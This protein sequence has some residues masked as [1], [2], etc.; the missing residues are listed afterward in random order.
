MSPEDQI[1]FKLTFYSFTIVFTILISHP[2]FP[3]SFVVYC[4]MVNAVC[5]SVYIHVCM[6]MCGWGGGGGNCAYAWV[7]VCFC[8]SCKKHW[9]I[10]MNSVMYYLY[11]N[12]QRL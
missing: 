8:A 11:K 3:N 7:C 2:F 5:I 12:I 4:Y 10:F 1:L 6:Y 9:A